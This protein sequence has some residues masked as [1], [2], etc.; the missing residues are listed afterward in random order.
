MTV[1]MPGEIG[2]PGSFAAGGA[3]GESGSV[4]TKKLNVFQD[5]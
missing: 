5:E 4:V 3:R 2:T 1:L